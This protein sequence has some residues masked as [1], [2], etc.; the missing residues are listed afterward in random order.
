MSTS[1]VR[2]IIR[3]DAT[4]QKVGFVIVD[5]GVAS[6]DNDTH[7]VGP[8]ADTVSEQFKRAALWMVGERGCTGCTLECGYSM[9]KVS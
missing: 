5:N 4:R 2:F 9:Q 8:D 6:F 3:H 7:V 1:T